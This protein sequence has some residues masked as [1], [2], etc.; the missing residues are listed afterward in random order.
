M[1]NLLSLDQLTHKAYCEDNGLALA[2]LDRLDEEVD[3]AVSAALEKNDNKYSYEVFDAVNAVECLINATWCKTEET[4]ETKDRI[5]YK[6]AG[7][8]EDTSPY[9]ND[10]TLYKFKGS[11]VWRLVVLGGEYGEDV[12]ETKFCAAGFKEAQQVATNQM[13]LMI[14]K[15]FQLNF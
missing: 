7:L 9:N 8:H 11:D 6:V 15:G 2:I 5:I 13:I 3:E 1:I 12:E 14:K 10:L 4:K